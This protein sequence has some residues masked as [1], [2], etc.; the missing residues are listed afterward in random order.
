VLDGVHARADRGLDAGCAVRMHCHFAARHVRFVDQRLH[1]LGRVLLRAGRVALGEDA[2]GA[3]ELDDVDAVLHVA[4][5]CF[6]HTR[7]AIRDAIGGVV[8][9]RREH[10]VV[11]VPAGDAERRSRD[12]HARAWNLAVVDSVAHRDVAVALGTDVTNRGDP[13]E[14]RAPGKG[15]ALQRESRYRHAIAEERRQ[16]RVGRDV[17]MSV[18]QPRQ[19]RVRAQVDDFRPRRNRDGI[20]RANGLDAI[21]AHHDHLIGD[22]LAV[23]HVYDASGADRA[24]RRVGCVDGGERAR[25]ENCRAQAQTHIHRAHRRGSPHASERALYF[26]F[27][28]QFSAM[29]PGP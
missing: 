17:R 10:V 21:A 13:G 1:F 15:R 11:A 22:D 26:C 2:A 23:L 27:F 9:F 25:G 12:Q 14:Q 20:R 28:I 24:D 18:D 4:A 16:R 8:E 19:H 3:A 7:D 29:I 5:N 6:A